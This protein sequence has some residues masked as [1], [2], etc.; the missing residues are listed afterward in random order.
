MNRRFQRRVSLFSATIDVLRDDYCIVDDDSNDQ[1]HCG[2]CDAVERSAEETQKEDDSQE[3]DR[4]AKSNP[5]RGTDVEEEGEL[6]SDDEAV[7]TRP[8]A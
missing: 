4:Y 8:Q 5:E 3:G 6:E 1:N 2:K 7:E